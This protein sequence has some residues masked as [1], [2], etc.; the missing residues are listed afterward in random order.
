LGKVLVAILDRGQWWLIKACHVLLYL[1]PDGFVPDGRMVMGLDKTIEWQ[2]G[3]EILT[4]RTH[5]VAVISTG[6]DLQAEGE[7]CA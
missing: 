1:L 5:R 7:A 6:V 2:S 4:K 3:E